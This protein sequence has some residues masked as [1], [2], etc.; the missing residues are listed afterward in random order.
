MRWKR[1]AWISEGKA[2]RGMD[3]RCDGIVK[4]REHGEGIDKIRRDMQ[5]CCG[6]LERKAK[7]WQR[8]RI[9]VR[10]DGYARTRAVEQRNGA[11]L[12]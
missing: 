6:D 3:T 12:R 11:G 2:E 10:S 9:A 5:R 1:V 8:H 4:Q 7:E